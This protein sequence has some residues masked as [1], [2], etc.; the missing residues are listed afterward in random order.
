MERTEGG[1]RRDLEWPVMR[2]TVQCC[3]PELV[4]KALGRLKKSGF[5]LRLI[6]EEGRRVRMG[7]GAKGSGLIAIPVNKLFET[8]LHACM[9]A[10]FSPQYFQVR[11]RSGVEAY[12]G[13]LA[14]PSGGSCQGYSVQGSSLG[15]ASL[16]GAL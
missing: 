7:G 16:G 2:A 14:R 9:H 1:S 11:P 5:S 13:G 6:G 10:P 3:G 8:T 15:H 12:G 4:T